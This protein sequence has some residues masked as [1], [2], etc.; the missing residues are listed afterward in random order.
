[1]AIR[2]RRPAP[3]VMARSRDVEV[4]RVGDWVHAQVGDDRVMMNTGSGEYLGVSAVGA[5][6]WDLLEEQSS[7]DDLCATLVSRYEVDPGT[8]REEVLA[9]LHELARLGAITLESSAK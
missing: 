3:R 4:R 5:V 6:I 9:F 8:C 1:M 7:V 2:M